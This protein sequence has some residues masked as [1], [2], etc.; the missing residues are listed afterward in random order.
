[1]SGVVSDRSVASRLAGL[2]LVMLV[3]G[4]VS[5]AVSYGL[6]GRSGL[7]VAAWATGLC[8]IPGWLVFLAEP[9]YRLPGQAIYGSLLGSIVRLAVVAGGVLLLVD[10]RPDLPRNVLIGCLAVLYL[11]GLA[12]ET[13]VLMQGLDLRKPRSGGQ[14]GSEESN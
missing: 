4:V 5:G 7:E 3:L 12:F 1:M 10:A 9:L 13:I 8:L 2:T 14:A 11:G 6:S